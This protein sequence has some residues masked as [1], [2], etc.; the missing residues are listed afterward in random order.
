MISFKDAYKKVLALYQDFGLEQIPLETAMGRVL[1][2]DIVA[3]RNFP[4]FNRATKDGIAI[5]LSLIH[6]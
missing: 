5:N 2:E 1:A 3:D 6:I 4:P